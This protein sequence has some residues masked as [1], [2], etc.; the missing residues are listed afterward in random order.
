MARIKERREIFFI[1]VEYRL[2]NAAVEV[3]DLPRGVGQ[4]EMQGCKE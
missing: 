3:K 1:G 4:V 2:E